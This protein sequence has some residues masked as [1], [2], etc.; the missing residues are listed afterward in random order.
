MPDEASVAFVEA[1]GATRAESPP[2][3]P[4]G[5][6]SAAA[7]AGDDAGAAG[8]RANNASGADDA[9]GGQGDEE[10]APASPGERSAVHGGN[11]EDEEGPASSEEPAI[12]EEAAK[13]A[14]LARLKALLHKND[15]GGAFPSGS[16]DGAAPDCGKSAAPG[17]FHEQ[18][19]FQD[20][21]AAGIQRMPRSFVSLARCLMAGGALP[22]QASAYCV[23]TCA[24][25]E[26]CRMVCASSVTCERSC[27]RVMGPCT[28][29][30]PA[31]SVIGDGDDDAGDVKAAEAVEAAAATAESRAQMLARLTAMVGR[32][33]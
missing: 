9:S 25:A 4:P 8:D 30:L 1:P 12:S 11:A 16:E 18:N 22:G 20:E 23:L 26:C 21:P 24:V 14:K 6:P 2:A 33:G 29:L 17:E 31:G 32:R 15:R 27:E 7:D 5:G 19:G 13:A 10:S 28:V 3:S